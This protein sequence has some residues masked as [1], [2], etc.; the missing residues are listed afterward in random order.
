MNDFP[1]DWMGGSGPHQIVVALS[2][3]QVAER[4]AVALVSE[5]EMLDRIVPNR[6]YLGEIVQS[7]VWMKAWRGRGRA[8]PVLRADME[9]GDGVTRIVFR[10]DADRWFVWSALLGF[11]VV[12]AG[13]VAL[14]FYTEQLLPALL[15]LL[16]GVFL[17]LVF[18][19]VRHES[20]NLLHFFL[21]LF[22][23]DRL[24][25]SLD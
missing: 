18:G 22:V 11:P 13:A 6:T 25:E 19:A 14:A 24:R 7:H 8:T 12:S 9:E 3:D 10:I 20:R 17:L 4:L 1:I 16:L 5:G 21:D 2:P 15:P 23:E